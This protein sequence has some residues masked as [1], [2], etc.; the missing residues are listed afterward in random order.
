MVVKSYTA[1]RGKFYFNDGTFPIGFFGGFQKGDIITLNRIV[2]APF[3]FH[4]Q[5]NEVKLTLGMLQAG[6][7]GV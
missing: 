3:I 5:I 6:V 7:E 2:N 4:K 1:F